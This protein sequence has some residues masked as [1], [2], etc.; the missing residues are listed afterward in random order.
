MTKPSLRSYVCHYHPNPMAPAETGV[1]P[2]IRLK[3]AD[4]D[5]AARL[6]FATLGMPI[7]RVER[8]E[9]AIDRR[10]ANDG[11]SPAEDSQRNLLVR[12][13]LAQSPRRFSGEPI[14]G[15]GALS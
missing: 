5:A 9:P 7:D 8:I 12:R 13:G 10:A 14:T 4:A 3:A 2:S 1:L 15:F 6:A 11:Q